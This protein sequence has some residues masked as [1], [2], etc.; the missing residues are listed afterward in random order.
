M[1]KQLHSSVWIHNT[2]GVLYSNKQRVIAEWI[3]ICQKG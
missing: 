2:D 3:L 1:F